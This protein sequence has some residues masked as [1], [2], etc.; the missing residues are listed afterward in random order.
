M[1]VRTYM[2]LYGCAAQC[3]A[4]PPLKGEDSLGS[5][6][7]RVPDRVGFIEDYGVPH[8]QEQGKEGGREGGR[9][10]SE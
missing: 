5:G 6:G 9:E 3:Y 4:A 10:G 2:V 1:N 8:L 7:V